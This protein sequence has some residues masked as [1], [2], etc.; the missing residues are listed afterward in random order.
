MDQLPTPQKP[1]L[2]KLQEP[3]RSSTVELGRRTPLPLQSF[4]TAL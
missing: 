2:E 1:E 3:A 4:S